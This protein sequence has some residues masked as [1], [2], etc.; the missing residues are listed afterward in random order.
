MVGIDDSCLQV[1]SQPDIRLKHMCLSKFIGANFVLFWLGGG[2]LG[3]W[4]RGG[5]QMI[6]CLMICISEANG[7]KSL[8]L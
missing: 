7:V 6:K 3:W 4:S 2:H 1:D 8:T 5:K